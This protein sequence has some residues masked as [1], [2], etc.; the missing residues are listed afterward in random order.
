MFS[1][2]L[3]NT[4][5]DIN[6]A[7]YSAV[8]SNS[9]SGSESE[10]QDHA[11]LFSAEGTFERYNIVQETWDW[12]YWYISESGAYISLEINENEYFWFFREDPNDP[13]S[14]IIRRS[15]NDVSEYAF[16]GFNPLYAGTDE[17]GDWCARDQEFIAVSQLLTGGSQKKWELVRYESLDYKDN[18]KTELELYERNYASGNGS[19]IW[20]GSDGSLLQYSSGTMPTIQYSSEWAYFPCTDTF[21]YG[22]GD[23]PFSTIGYWKFKVTVISATTF[24]IIDY[25]EDN[26]TYSREIYQRIP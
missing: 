23:D 11:F 13:N 21:H 16:I 10:L 22:T 26:I 25:N 14:R 18:T 2:I 15:S 24:S 5:A 8:K 3:S 1:S 19:Q 17:S 7:P 12:G 20:L 6:Y 9:T 4:I